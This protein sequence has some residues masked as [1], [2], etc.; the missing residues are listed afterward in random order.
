MFP[1]FHWLFLIILTCTAA[2]LAAADITYPN[3]DVYTGELKNGQRHGK[4][5]MKYANGRE[6]SGEWFEDMRK[7][8]G[9][10]VWKDSPKYISY[11]GLWDDNLPN[12]SG[13]MKFKSG[14]TYR[15]E[16]KDARFHGQATVTYPSGDVRYGNFLNGKREGD[17][18]LITAR[19]RTYRE[20]FVQDQRTSVVNITGSSP[21]KTVNRGS[22]EWVLDPHRIPLGM[23]IRA[24]HDNKDLPRLGVKVGDLIQE[25][26]D[27]KLTTTFEYQK[28]DRTLMAKEKPCTVKLQRE[29]QFLILNDIQ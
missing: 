20:T 29:G 14:F 10:Q 23:R 19:K 26:C 27:I 7:G 17:F 8:Y 5:R 3:G 28:A 2:R 22:V 24:F 11:E 15:G 21:E 13:T 1:R 12:G 18:L 4:G 9:S 25:L 16:F 6:Y